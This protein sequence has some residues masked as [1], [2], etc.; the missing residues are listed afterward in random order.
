MCV[1][2]RDDLTL[3]V[4]VALNLDTTKQFVICKYF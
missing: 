2:D 1:T 4:K 3:A